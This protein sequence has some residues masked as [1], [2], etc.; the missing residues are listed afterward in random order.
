VAEGER[1]RKLGMR[2]FNIPLDAKAITD[3]QVEEFMQH[4][5]NPENMPMLIHCAAANRVGGLWLIHRVLKDGWPVEKAEEE[6]KS[7][8]LRTEALRQFAL[9]Y[10]AKHQSPKP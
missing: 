10:I 7:I 4:V 9:D 1:I 5:G 6:A 3:A 8:G 2:Y